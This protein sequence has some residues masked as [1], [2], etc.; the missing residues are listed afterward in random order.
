MGQKLHIA[1]LSLH[2]CPCG[3]LG[4]RYTGGMN[5]YIRNTATELI[6]QGHRV[7]IFTCSHKND[8]D[9][10]LEF[11]GHHINLIH[12][13]AEDFTTISQANLD[14]HVSELCRAVINYSVANSLHY[15]IIQSHYWL[16]G[17]VG[18]KLKHIWSVPH[19]TMFHTLGLIKNET[20]LG[21][22]EP[23][24]RIIKERSIISSCDLIV[25][26]TAIEKKSLMDKYDAE[27]TKISVIPCG[28]NPALFR[29]LN[30]QTAREI[31]GLSDQDILLFVGRSDPVKGLDNLLKAISLLKRHKDLHLI[32]I[33]GDDSSM[34]E[35]RQTIST[36][37]K[38]AI[39]GNIQLIGPVPHEQM[40]LY[41][42]AAD[43]C[44]I[45]SYYESFSLVALEAIACNTPILATDV[46]DIKAISHGCAHCRI[47]ENND[48]YLLSTC[49][50]ALFDVIQQQPHQPYSL[51]RQYT[52][53]DISEKIS[54]C[55]YTLLTSSAPLIHSAFTP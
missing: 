13:E 21:K 3:R 49:I 23:Q 31:C 24:Y 44:V 46:G 2:S 12:I 50:D 11:D 15:D 41:Y 37:E 29:P 53:G 47:I 6:K 4:S 26:S 16:S 36:W 18:E 42:N 48:P 39:G 55:Y 5:I 54:N 28:V 17:M 25:A 34:S 51:P 7:D 9:C 35:V 20:S 22:I 27:E 14:A 38:C 43:F 52:W 8:H 19:A 45:P 32:I 1:I 10:R 33:G 40:Y 30:K